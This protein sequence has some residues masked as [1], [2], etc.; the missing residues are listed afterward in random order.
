MHSSV[1]DSCL[2]SSIKQW[3]PF[4]KWSWLFIFSFFS[5]MTGRARRTTTSLQSSLCFLLASNHRG[6]VF[7]G[8]LAYTVP[9]LCKVFSIKSFKQVQNLAALKTELQQL[10]LDLQMVCKCLFSQPG[11][12]CLLCQHLQC[13]NMQRRTAHSCRQPKY[14]ISTELTNVVNKEVSYQF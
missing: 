5:T 13:L 11:N 3:S 8:S 4:F 1:T 12:I 6:F 10:S 2:C 9:F 14:F 7:W